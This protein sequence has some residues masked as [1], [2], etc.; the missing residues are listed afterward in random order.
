[1]ARSALISSSLA[2]RIVVVDIVCDLPSSVQVPIDLTL[3]FYHRFIGIKRNRLNKVEV[4][5]VYFGT[6]SATL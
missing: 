3:L 5:S 4:F 1:M 6:Q 2:I